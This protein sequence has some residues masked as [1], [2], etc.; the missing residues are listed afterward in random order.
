MD[1]K[2]A[3]QLAVNVV[4]P[5]V[6]LLPDDAHCQIGDEAGY[7]GRAVFSLW[8]SG[9]ESLRPVRV[10]E[11]P[12]DSRLRKMLFPHPFQRGTDQISIGFEESQWNPG[13]LDF[14]SS[15]ATLQHSG[16]LHSVLLRNDV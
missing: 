8:I 14:D 13:K 11:I 3:P 1:S 9:F 7:S 2:F 16:V 15:C 10:T 5:S 12:V 4:V 6:V